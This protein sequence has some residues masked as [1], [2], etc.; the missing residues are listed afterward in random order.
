MYLYIYIKIWIKI[1]SLYV[2]IYWE[3]VNFEQKGI[4]DQV[5]KKK[6]LLNK[7]YMKDIQ[8]TYIVPIS[9]YW[10]EFW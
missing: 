8:W 5:Y 7:F 6:M 9:L 2:F 3:H 10:A 4:H 1:I